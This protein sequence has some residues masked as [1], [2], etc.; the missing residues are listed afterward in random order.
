[1][2][3][4]AQEGLAANQ[5]ETNKNVREVLGEKKESKVNDSAT[6]FT[7]A[8]DFA[9]PTAKTTEKKIEKDGI[10][11]LDVVQTV[12]LL[13]DTINALVQSYGEDG[14]NKK[15]NEIKERYP[16]FESLSE[17]KQKEIVMEIFLDKP[18]S[19]AATV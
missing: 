11:G 15:I 1:L 5:I 18:N 6:Y 19:I 14:V 13:S 3:A 12:S 10:A 9:K 16:D 2:L 8:T 17:A 4:N 7:T